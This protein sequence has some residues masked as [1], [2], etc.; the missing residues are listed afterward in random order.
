MW[1]RSVNSVTESLLAPFKKRLSGAAGDVRELV[2]LV[3][4]HLRILYT[5]SIA[6]SRSNGI[7]S[8]KVIGTPGFGTMAAVVRQAAKESKE[9]TK[10]AWS[11]R[12]RLSAAESLNE[13]DSFK[14]AKRYKSFKT[15]RDQ[16]SHG[17]ALPSDDALVQE[18]IQSL[19]VITRNLQVILNKH[20]ADCSFEWKENYLRIFATS[21]KDSLDVDG[22]RSEKLNRTI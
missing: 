15:M 16:L 10:S 11:E 19:T 13:I 18:I 5:L 9:V 2:A 21:K 22:L 1:E 7:A 8:I 14:L 12:I 3:D 20:F 17:H 4:F 6:D